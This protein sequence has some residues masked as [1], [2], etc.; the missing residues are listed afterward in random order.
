MRMRPRVWQT[1][2]LAA[3]VLY[4]TVPVVATVRFALSVGGEPSL[5]PLA[6]L[7]SR[8]EFGPT[9]LRSTVLSLATVALALLITVPALVVVTLRLP[10]L[11][12]LVEALAL[13]PFVIP[14]VIL[15]LGLHGLYG[16]PPFVL[17]GSPVVLVVAYV[18][19]AL[20][21]MVRSVDNALTAIDARGLCEAAESLGAGFTTTLWRVLLPNLRSG[22][23]AGSLLT[24]A[25]AFGEFTLANLLVGA[26][27][28][29]F[30]VFMRE[31]PDGH[32]QSAVA[33]ISFALTFIISG[34]VLWIG[35][36][37]ARLSGTGAV[38]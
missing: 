36:R 37:D 12:T 23:V 13:L 6:S 21:L 34:A 26:A 25:T 3:V 18:I 19:T 10:R 1:A 5:K 11:R 32:E 14:G 17:T 28:K 9:L 31:L 20:P 4:L 38:R 2:L 15:A 24:F 30:P 35:G 29:T 22:L 8:P 27:W 7:V 16:A 33:V